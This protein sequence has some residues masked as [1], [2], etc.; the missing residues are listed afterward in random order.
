MSVKSKENVQQY[1]D[2]V[3]QI[4]SAIENLKEFMQTL[5]APDENFQLANLDYESTLSVCRIHECIRE[6]M[7]AADRVHRIPV[8]RYMQMVGRGKRVEHVPGPF[9]KPFTNPRS[10][11]G[12]PKR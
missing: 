1:V 3:S 6:A 9:E 8:N 5:P 7:K 2:Q 12:L 4:L 11:M 10:G